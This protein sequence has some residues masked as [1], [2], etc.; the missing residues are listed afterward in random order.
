M[1]HLDPETLVGHALEGGEHPHLAACSRCREAAAALRQTLAA[2]ADARHAA[3]PPLPLRRW[4]LAYAGCAL[5][6]RPRPR[7]LALLA[8]SAGPLA[9][10][11]AGAAPAAALYG[12]E[13]FQVD[14]RLEPDAAGARL[15][16]QVVAVDDATPE[17][18]TITAVG[19]DGVTSTVTSDSCGEFR[20]DGR[21]ARWGVTVVAERAGERLVVS[22]F[23]GGEGL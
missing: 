2:L 19:P 14:L 21:A 12:D 1:R 10:V 20:I 11:R 18:W 22:R 23:D 15:H 3:H 4:A 8:A 17:P 16:G 5:P 6:D 7:L 13:R 9:E